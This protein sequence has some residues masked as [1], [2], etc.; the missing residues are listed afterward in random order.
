MGKGKT[1]GQFHQLFMSAF[2][3]IFLTPPKN[4]TQ[5]LNTRKLY[6]KLL[7]E[8]SERKMLVKLTLFRLA[9]TKK[10]KLQSFNAYSRVNTT[11][12]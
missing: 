12:L 3:P 5:N 6:S 10:Q 8:K 2:A 11:C 9:R 1:F 4:Q 7:Y